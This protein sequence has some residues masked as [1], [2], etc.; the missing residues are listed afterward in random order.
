MIKNAINKILNKRVL[1]PITKGNEEIE[2]ITI[3][4]I[5]RRANLTVDICSI[6]ND[7]TI[8]LLRGLKI[9]KLY[10]L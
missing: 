9:V 2:S 6:N 10:L 3:T 8:E 1:L 5:L 4:N 7:K